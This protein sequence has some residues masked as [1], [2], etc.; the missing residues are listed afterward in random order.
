MEFPFGQ[1]NGFALLMEFLFGN[2]RT[3]VGALLMEFLHGNFCPVGV[4]L[5]VGNHLVGAL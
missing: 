1:G 2:F 5:L 3:V 4:V